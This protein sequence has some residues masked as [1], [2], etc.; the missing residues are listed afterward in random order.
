MSNANPPIPGSLKESE[1]RFRLLVEGVRDYA[2]FMLDP[3]G[4]VASW[5]AGAERIKG[6]HADEIIGKHFSIFYP[7][8]QVESGFPDYEL[9][10]TK[11]E[12]RFEDEGWRVRKD[13]TTFWANVV[14][15]A[16]RD[17][18]GVLQGFAKVTRDMTERRAHEEKLRRSEERFR[19]LV[20]GV[21]DY[22]IFMLDPTGHIVSWNAGAERI[23]GYRAD[24]IIGK[25]FSVFYPRE[26]VESGFP[27]YELEVT[28]VEGR[29]EDE[30][31]RVR[32]D[33]STFW[34][35]VVITALYDDS[36]KLY[37]FAKVTRDMTE[38]KR[39]EALELAERQMLEFLAM[40]S[41]E[42]RNPLAPISNAVYMLHM[43]T[44][45]D[46]ELRWLRDVIERQ[47]GQLTRLVDDLLEV[48]RVTSGNIRLQRETVEL[49]GLVAQAIESSR[50][51][52][53]A[54]RHHLE[55]SMPPEAIYVNGDAT[56]LSQIVVNLLNNSAKYTPE[57][58]RI[59]VSVRSEGNDAAIR[60]RDNGVGIT[61]EFMPKIFDLFTQG[62]RTL[63][64]SEGGLGIGLTL[65]RRLVEMHG[66]T[67]EAHSQ[68]AGLGSEF[69]VVLPLVERAQLGADIPDADRQAIGG[70]PSMRVLIVDDNV[71]AAT[72]MMLF[73]RMWG[74]DA[75]MAHDGISAVEAAGAYHPDVV[76]LDL[77]LP[78]LDG[79]EVAARLRGE[80]ELD[81]IPLIA[82][83]GYGQEEDRRRTREA[84]FAYHFVKPVDPEKLHDLLLTIRAEREAPR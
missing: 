74:F 77:G 70:R 75:R 40:L 71:D 2:I 43:K 5:N 29:F 27:Q 10:V 69:R 34:A 12:G 65:V 33:G 47:V 18:N 1:E 64:R 20:E 60:V 61:P 68:G 30:G 62:E 21:R 55:V 66:G 26:K 82:V 81:G 73:V 3:E 39:V 37:G 72:S 48:S 80:A 22:A 24:E 50:P 58:G 7:R 83:T 41:H 8:E 38:R 79:Y 9:E 32:R 76:L 52:L 25:H 35:N 46:P 44:I 54:R 67:I 56:R 36:G 45:D 19:L 14:I 53:D 17:S 15:T 31:W 57:G 42:L 49:T 78:R 23:K 28:K 84:G 51:L 16:L 63:D 11:V 6:Y 59:E 4:Y 13:G